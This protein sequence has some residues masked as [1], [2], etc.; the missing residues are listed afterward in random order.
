MPH[1]AGLLMHPLQ[2]ISALAGNRRAFWASTLA[3]RMTR[4][5][6]LRLS[7]HTS[8]SLAAAALLL[9]CRPEPKPPADAAST[10][11]AVRSAAPHGQT[12]SLNYLMASAGDDFRANA[13]GPVEVR[14]V[15]F[16]LRDTT[17]GRASYVL[18]GEFR[19]RAGADTAQWVPF[20]TVETSKYEQWLGETRFCQPL[21]GSWDDSDSLTTR[22]QQELR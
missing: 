15:R 21:S 11:A 10:S 2:L 7:L 19:H 22:L 13:H 18:C 6:S 17:G 16:G 4:S 14:N 5:F 8:L 9:A 12:A 1:R 20:A 3:D